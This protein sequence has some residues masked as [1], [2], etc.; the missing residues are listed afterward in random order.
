MTGT[1]NKNG[2]TLVETVVAIFVFSVVVIASQG[3]FGKA[4]TVVKSGAAA[5]RVQESVQ[6]A[7]ELM[8]RDIRMSSI[9]A[10]QEDASCALSQL[11]LVHPILGAVIYRHDGVAI[12]RTVDGVSG[13]ITAGEVLIQDLSFCVRHAGLDGEQTRVT[14]LIN[15]VYDS[16]RVS[17]QKELNVQTTVS[18]RDYETE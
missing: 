14:I 12:E 17:E 1:K 15:A 8:A 5:Q 6:Y 11:T 7:L 13:H 2:F 18:L 9:S 3:V 4:L 16:E 10:D